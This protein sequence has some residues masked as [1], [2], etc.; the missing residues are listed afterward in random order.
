MPSPFQQGTLHSIPIPLSPFEVL[1]YN[2]C[3]ICVAIY[4]LMDKLG[5]LVI[6]NSLTL[7]VSY[8]VDQ[9]LLA[10]NFTTILNALKELQASQQKTESQLKDLSSLKEK[11]DQLGA[12]VEKLEKNSNNKE[13]SS[14]NNQNS[15]QG[16]HSGSN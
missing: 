11:Y 12:K 9:H 4:L 14:N 8:Q 2:G 5:D 13:S 3:M 15:G 1:L 6:D 10:K 7:T 16:D